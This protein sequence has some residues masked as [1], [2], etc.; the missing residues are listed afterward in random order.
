MINENIKLLMEET[1]CEE[2]EATAALELAGGNIE[3]AI[4][5]VGV[6]LKYITAYKAKINLK[7]DNIFGLVHIITNNKNLDL[8]KFSSIMSYNPVVYE[9]DCSAD[10]FSF[11]KAIYSYRLID[12]AIEKYTKNI[13][14]ALKDFVFANLKQHKILTVNDMKTVLEEFFLDNNAQ[15]EIVAEELTLRDFKKLPNYFPDIHFETSGNEDTTI[16]L[17]AVILEDSEG[18][19]IE[20]IS[21]GDNVLAKIIDERDISHYLGH[22]IGAMKDNKMIPVMVSVQNIIKQED[23]YDV[24]LKYADLIYGISKVEFGRTLKVLETKRL[25]WWK[26]LTTIVEDK[27][28]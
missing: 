5:N 1:G 4:I 14:I 9:Q 12:G 21:V 17:E 11:E 13:D 24:Y 15:I 22:L 18:K 28:T 26:G 19:K 16:D 3:Q 23:H 27:T 25:P 20:D 2:Q 6:M 7:N 10:W 8:L